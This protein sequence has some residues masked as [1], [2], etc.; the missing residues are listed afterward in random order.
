MRDEMREVLLSKSK[1]PYTPK[2]FGILKEQCVTDGLCWLKNMYFRY[3]EEFYTELG[4]ALDEQRKREVRFV[5]RGAKARKR[6]AILF[7]ESRPRVKRSY[8]WLRENSRPFRAL[9]KRRL[10]VNLTESV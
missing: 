6:A 1:V 8:D 7:I 2:R 3:D 5:G 10:G 4:T 9:L